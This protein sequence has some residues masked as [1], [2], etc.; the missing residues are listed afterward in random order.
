MMLLGSSPASQLVFPWLQDISDKLW[1]A[2]WLFAVQGC[3][4]FTEKENILVT[5]IWQRC[6][7][8]GPDLVKYLFLHPV[9]SHVTSTLAGGLGILSPN[10]MA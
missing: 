5:K 8:S 7:R 3:T 6:R 9:L 4:I 2:R 1:V 10:H